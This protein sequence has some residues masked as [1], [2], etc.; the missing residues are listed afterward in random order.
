MHHRT[1]YRSWTEKSLTAAIRCTILAAQSHHG[2]HVCL[3]VDGLDEFIGQ[4]DDLVDLLLDLQAF[5]NVKCCVASRPEL[6]LRERLARCPHLRVQDL[7]ERDIGAFVYAK[8]E[9]LSQSNSGSGEIAEL[10]RSVVSRAEGVFLWAALVTQS[11]T[12][13]HRAGDDI[14]VLK[15]RLEYL[16]KDLVDLFANMVANI[17]PVY[18]ESLAHHLRCMRLFYD[19]GRHSQKRGPNIAFLTATRLP[20]QI[21]SYDSFARLCGQT[22]TQVVEQSAGLLEIYDRHD[23]FVL[24]AVWHEASSKYLVPEL[25]AGTHTGNLRPAQRKR[26]HGACEFPAILAYE[27]RCSQWIHRSAHEYVFPRDGRLGPIHLDN[28]DDQE[29]IQRLMKGAVELCMSAPSSSSVEAAGDNTPQRTATAAMICERSPGTSLYEAMDSLHDFIVKL[30]PTDACGYVYKQINSDAPTAAYTFWTTCSGQCPRYVISRLDMML[31]DMPELGTLAQ[32]LCYCSS[33]STSLLPCTWEAQVMRV[34]Y[35]AF[36][37]E[38]QSADEQSRTTILDLRCVVPF[39]VTCTPRIR[40]VDD[41]LFYSTL[42]KLVLEYTARIEPR[43]RNTNMED[44][45]DIRELQAYHE[46]KRLLGAMAESINMQLSFGFSRSDGFLGDEKCGRRLLVQYPGIKSATIDGGPDLAGAYRRIMTR[47]STGLRRPGPG[48]TAEHWDGL[49]IV[50]VTRPLPRGGHGYVGE[51][52]CVSFAVRDQTSYYIMEVLGSHAPKLR[53]WLFGAFVSRKKL[54]ALYKRLLAEVWKNDCG[55][56]ATQQLLM[57]ACIRTEIR[58]L[59]TEDVQRQQDHDR[60]Q[61]L[62]LN[63]WETRSTSSD[64]GRPDEE[65]DEACSDWTEEGSSAHTRDDIPQ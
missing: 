13:G 40:K 59:N 43:F 18:R 47:V 11:V 49:S 19:E 2:T 37:S 51:L 26:Y 29:T 24:A 38:P 7:N 36:G 17:E 41:P 8:M 30:D 46:R 50:G 58:H 27:G 61:L 34:L 4:Y 64:Q 39:A 65:S 28:N 56:D 15:K 45:S 3:F 22:E 20:G 54:R 12:R 42:G 25:L 31:A 35:S 23:P 60:D 1:V 53:E 10:R 44:L 52:R 55:V 9:S 21:T 5:D 62:D 32:M 14:D 33:W 16:P 57:L 6:E 63:P 48:V